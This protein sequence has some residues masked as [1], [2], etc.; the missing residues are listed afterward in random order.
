MASDA[1]TAFD[2]KSLVASLPAAV[3]ADLLARSNRAGLW[4][5]ARHW[6][7]LALFGGMVAAGWPLWQW[8]VLPFSALLIFNF[9]LLHECTHQTP[10]RS[11]WLS[12]AVG[13]IAGALVG[14]PFLWFRYFHL[15]HHR[16][17]QDPARDPELRHGE[18]ETWRVYLWHLSGIPV[19]VGQIKTLFRAASGRELE[20][21]VPRKAVRKIRLEAALLLALYGAVLL[22]SL[23]VS[24]IFLRLWLL[25]LL[26]GQPLLRL[27][28]LAEHGRCPL[29]ANMLENSRTTFTNRFI[30]FLAWNMPYHAEH[31]SMP[32]V[33][34]HKLAAL[35]RLAAPH[36]RQV[37][38]GYR[39]FHGDYIRHLRR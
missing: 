11:P 20:D 5:L 4:H 19:W 12:E 38:A 10:F 25:P 21:F 34:F 26:L 16:F 7:L 3:R 23:Y 24:A 8:A 30:R 39:A 37:S 27:Y 6:G 17:T 1:Q 15:A 35:N 31:H 33:P 32:M 9:T 29:V 13:R 18:P 2:H 22:F 36:L 14:L 28:L